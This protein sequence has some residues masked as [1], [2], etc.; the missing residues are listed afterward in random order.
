RQIQ[1]EG[2]RGDFVRDTKAVSGPGHRAV[3]K[4]RTPAQY[5]QRWVQIFGYNLDW[6][7]KYSKS[8]FDRCF[9]HD[10]QTQSRDVRTGCLMN[11]LLAH[12]V[13]AASRAPSAHNTQPWQLRW[14]ENELQVCVAEQRMLR[15]ADP[16]GFDTLHELG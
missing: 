3:V 16:E 9:W 2:S 14:E 6:R 12:L 7:R 11:T 4:C 8:G 1:V 13:E 10:A 15:V 5:A